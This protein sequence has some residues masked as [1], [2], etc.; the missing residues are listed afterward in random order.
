MRLVE[1]FLE[2]DTAQSVLRFGIIAVAI[3]NVVREHHWNVEFFGKCDKFFCDVFLVV[4]PVILHFD[5]IIFCAEQIAVH[6]RSFFR[7][8]V[9]IVQ[10]H[11]RNNALNAGGKTDNSLVIFFEQFKIDTRLSEM[12][13]FL[14]RDTRKPR[15]IFVARFIFTQQNKVIILSAVTVA[16]KDGM[17]IF[18]NVKFFA[19]DGIDSVFPAQVIKVQHA[20]HIAVVGE[21]ERLHI[22]RLCARNQRIYF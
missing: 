3:V 17:V 21:R 1:Q 10:E 19:D 16:L 14:K 6:K 9:V 8:F 18:G 12:Q 20:E 22:E 5:V 2:S 13:S 11:L 15:H 7:F 4:K